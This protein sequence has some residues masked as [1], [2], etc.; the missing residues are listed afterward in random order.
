[1]IDEGGAGE[2]G[3][4]RPDMRDLYENHHTQQRP[5]MWGKERGNSRSKMNPVLDG[6]GCKHRSREPWRE[7]GPRLGLR[8][9]W[10]EVM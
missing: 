1:M 2:Y 8:I 7:T 10:C 4:Q 9:T 5:G 3:N 6:Q